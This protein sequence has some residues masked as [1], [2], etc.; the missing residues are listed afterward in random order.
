M[1]KYALIILT[2]LM[3]FSLVLAGCTPQTQI[4]TAAQ[5]MVAQTL[6]AMAVVTDTPEPTA[7]ST[8]EPTA[9]NT[10]TEEPAEPEVVAFGPT[11]FPRD[12]NPLTGLK[13][14]DP[15]L[16]DRRPILIKVANFPSSGRP[17]AGL[18]F[19]DIVFE[20]YIGEG[21]NRFM[22]LYYGQDS[23]Q[24]GPVRSGRLV[25][26]YLAMMYGGV[27][28]F[29]GADATVYSRIVE[30]LGDRAITGT[31]FT[32]PAICDN[33]ENIVTSIF[34]D[35]TGFDELLSSRGIDNSRQELDG[36]RF[37]P[38]TPAGGV[39]GKQANVTFNIM[40]K[41]QWIYDQAS[42]KYLRW[43]EETDANYNV[44]MIPLV[45]R[46]TN[47]QLGFSNVVILSATYT[48]YKP[49]LHDIGIWDNTSGQRAIIFRDGQAFDVLWRTVDATSPI[50]FMTK[51]GEIFA[52]KP[53]N[54]WMVIMGMSSGVKQEA[55]TWDFNFFL[56]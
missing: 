21:L 5:T 6:T 46:I 37:D 47:E 11:G 34:G 27:L 56:P 22:A 23:T 18:S 33:G 38:V 42:G 55:G 48:E 52:L 25:D 15:A 10:P 35:S 3:V 17:H 36:M 41:G 12:V 16:L 13:V 24:I 30:V 45:D 50:E 20:Y 14:K 26:P 51:D 9:T 4:S 7:T 54:T 43:I 8:L 49:A 31:E 29:K 40:D 1:K 44:K 19:A 39:D 32:C 28:A 53:G 2:A